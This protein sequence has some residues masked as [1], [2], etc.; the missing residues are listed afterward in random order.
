MASLD[1]GAKTLI[2]GDWDGTLCL[3]E[4]RNV[5]DIADNEEQPTKKSKTGA[6]ASRSSK[7][8]KHVVP[9]MA[10]QA[11]SSKISGL[12][13]GNAEKVRSSTLDRAVSGSWD[14][15]IKLWDLSREECIMTLN[16]S[17]VV[18]CLDTSY[19]SSG[20]VA[21][22]HPDCAIRLWDVRSNDS[23][24][25]GSLAL[26]DNT[27]RISHK[28]WITAVKWSPLNPY[29]LIS[30]SHDG[31]IKVWDIRSSIP[32]HS[33]RAFDAEDKALCLATMSSEDGMFLFSGGTD[34]VIKEYYADAAT[35][36]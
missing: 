9:A 6:S 22:G 8:T 28:A 31:I 16:G 30:T 18:S 11:H 15:S 2:S 13:F 7:G 14:H 1:M 12:S 29:H 20:I 25:E 21:T 33:V 10:L 17:R 4:Y 35:R 27:F 23:E 19:H 36:R 3:W 24:K 26:T 5:Q 32:L 34:R